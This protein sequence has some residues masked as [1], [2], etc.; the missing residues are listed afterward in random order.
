MKR[1]TKR[2]LHGLASA[3]I[4]G[5]ASAGSNMLIDGEHFNLWSFEG[6]KKTAEAAVVMGFLGSR[7]Y[8][9]EAPLPPLREPRK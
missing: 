3:F 9:Q 1:T 6:I 4:M 2:W 5:I 7:A 8:L